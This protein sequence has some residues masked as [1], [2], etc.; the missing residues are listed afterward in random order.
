MKPILFKYW[1]WGVKLKIHEEIFSFYK[2]RKTSIFSNTKWRSRGSTNRCICS[3]ILNF[4]GWRWFAGKIENK[5]NSA[6]FGLSLDLAESLAKIL[7]QDSLDIQFNADSSKAYVE[8][9][10]KLLG[11]VKNIAPTAIIHK[12]D[13]E[14]NLEKLTAKSKWYHKWPC[15][16]SKKMA[17]KKTVHTLSVNYQEDWYQYE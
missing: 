15:T 16:G 6:Q 2:S 4:P 10:N 12:E 5:A 17:G 7:L 11:T 13:G 14:N 8:N 9:I 3:D 1:I